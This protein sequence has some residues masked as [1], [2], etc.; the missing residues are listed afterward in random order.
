MRLIFGSVLFV[1]LLLFA[2]GCTQPAAQTAAT[3]A[4]TAI[5]T[6]LSQTT[7]PPVTTTVVNSQTPGPTQ[8]LQAIWGVDVQVNSNGEAINPQII[9]TFQG[10]KGLNVIPLIEVIVTRSD[11]TVESA[12]MTQPLFIGKTVSLTGTYK[13]GASAEAWGTKDRAEVWVTTPQ[14][15]RIKTF[16]AYVP[17][18]SYN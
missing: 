6:T 10:G 15:D 11:G 9:A 3:P 18:R 5:P 12:R 7:V 14:G 4:P 8:T 16:D 17:F 1:A 13:S 2:A